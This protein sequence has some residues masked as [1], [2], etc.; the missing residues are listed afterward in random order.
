LTVDHFS[1]FRKLAVS[2]ASA[3]RLLIYFREKFPRDGIQN[4]RVAGRPCA[5][6]GHELGAR[7]PIF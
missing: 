3:T 5:N 7:A 4:T 1:Y 6:G 2:R